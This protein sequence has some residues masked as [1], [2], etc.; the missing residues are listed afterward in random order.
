MADLQVAPASV[1]YPCIF[2][3]FVDP[4]QS[5]WKLK[6]RSWIF[7][8]A[9]L[10]KVSSFPAGWSTPYQAEA[11]STGG[12]FIGG[13]GQVQIV[14]YSESPVGE[15]EIID[16]ELMYVPGRWKYSDGTKA[17]RITQIYVSTRVSIMN[18]RKNWNIP[19]HLADFDI[20]TTSDGTTTISVSH[21]GTSVP[22]FKASTKKIPVVSSLSIHSSTSVFGKY[23]GLVQPPLPVGEVPE[24]VGTSQWAALTPILRGSTS[25]RTMTP[26]LAG[27]AGDGVGFPAV[28]PWPI[29][30]SMENLDVEFGEAVMQDGV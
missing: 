12:T 15:R 17:W 28:A 6:G 18:G 30:V 9:P 11:L 23:F 25:L 29:A 16:D 19:K 4:V 8:L 13:I 26:G 10:S 3:I 7:P 14:S 24:N 1:V 27:K 22:F 21:P 5:P 2:G 20:S